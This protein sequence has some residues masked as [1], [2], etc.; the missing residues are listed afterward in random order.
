MCPHTNNDK[1]PSQHSQRVAPLRPR[2]RNA[3]GL[4]GVAAPRAYRHDLPGDRTVVALWKSHRRRIHKVRPFRFCLF[5]MI[6]I[7]CYQVALSH[8]HNRWTD[9]P[10]FPS[11]PNMLGCC[12]CSAQ[13]AIYAYFRNFS[14]GRH[15]SMKGRNSDA[16][17]QQL[18]LEDA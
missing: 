5:N 7:F 9:Q 3:D 8:S 6:K 16:G 11:F 13:L 15:G 1:P 2:P 4:G 18:L 12:I 17:S 14:E 10:F